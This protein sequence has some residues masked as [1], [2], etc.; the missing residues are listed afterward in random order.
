MRMISPQRTGII[1]GGSR[2]TT[3]GRCLLQLGSLSHEPGV[4]EPQEYQA[5]YRLGILSCCEVRVGPELI[6]RSSEAVFQFLERG[7][8][9]WRLDPF[10]SANPHCYLSRVIQ[11]ANPDFLCGA[12]TV[13][14]ICAIQEWGRI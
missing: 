13:L 11:I 7:S 3:G 6:S 9:F 10:Q 1:D 14:I 2:P 8:L 5:E 12:Y 4:S